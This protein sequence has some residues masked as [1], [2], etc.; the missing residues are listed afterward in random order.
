MGGRSV[1]YLFGKSRA[2]ALHWQRGARWTSLN[3]GDIRAGWS[4]KNKSQNWKVEEPPGE[5]DM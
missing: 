3:G 4:L 2:G 1:A 5:A